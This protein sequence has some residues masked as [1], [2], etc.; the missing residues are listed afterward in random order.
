MFISHQIGGVISAI[1]LAV[2][3]RN[4]KCIIQKFM[5]FIQAPNSSYINRLKTGKAANTVKNGIL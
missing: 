1:E 2:L 4:F 5:P 3:Q